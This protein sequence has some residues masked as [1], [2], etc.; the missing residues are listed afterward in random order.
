MKCLFL[1]KSCS[2]IR[3]QVRD[4]E[5]LFFFCEKWKIRKDKNFNVK[6][7]QFIGWWCNFCFVKIQ[8]L[9][10]HIA[11]YDFTLLIFCKLMCDYCSQK[12]V[13]LFLGGC[14][15]PVNVIFSVISVF[16]YIWKT[17]Y[18][19][20]KDDENVWCLCRVQLFVSSTE[21]HKN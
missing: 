16:K 20:E 21:K 2:A 15:D 6:L 7:N 14:N 5:L 17:G 11:T 18:Y 9:F 1:Y 4:L 3:Q 19:S 12:K 13:Y 8:N 10:M